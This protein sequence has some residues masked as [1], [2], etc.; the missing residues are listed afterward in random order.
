MDGGTITLF[1]L[2]G[3][4]LFAIQL[5]ASMAD[6]RNNLD[7]SRFPKGVYYFK[8]KTENQDVTRKVILQ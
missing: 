6:Y 3:Q 1:D 2:H 8:L 5:A 7:I 4:Q